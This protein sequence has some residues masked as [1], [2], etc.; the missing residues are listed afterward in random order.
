[1]QL[2]AVLCVYGGFVRN[3]KLFAMNTYTFFIQRIRIRPIL[4]GPLLTPSTH[5]YFKS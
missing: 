5:M 2:K 4:F 3:E 1:M